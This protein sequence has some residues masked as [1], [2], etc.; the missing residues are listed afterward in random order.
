MHISI[1]K[2]HFE[3]F[4]L[5]T[6]FRLFPGA[7]PKLANA[8]HFLSSAFPLGLFSSLF[9]IF[10]QIERKCHLPSKWPRSQPKG[11]EGMEGQNLC[12]PPRPFVPPKFL[13]LERGGPG[14]NFPAVAPSLYKLRL[15]PLFF[16]LSLFC[17]FFGERHK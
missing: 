9:I 7:H 15:L 10:P 5:L 14:A 1:T 4:V 6:L 17:P 16:V 12:P 2:I 11:K 13:A 8:K 3:K